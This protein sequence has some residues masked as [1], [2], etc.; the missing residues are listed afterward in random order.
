MEKLT[1]TQH[2]MYILNA[3]KVDTRHGAR[4]AEME[5]DNW[6][7]SYPKVNACR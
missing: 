1:G 7:V 6:Q 5:D 2:N 3:A 4:V